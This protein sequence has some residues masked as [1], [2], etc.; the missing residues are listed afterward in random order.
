MFLTSEI[1]LACASPIG[2]AVLSKKGRQM[3]PINVTGDP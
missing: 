3:R 2:L 1:T